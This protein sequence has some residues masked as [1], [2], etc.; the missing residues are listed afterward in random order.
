MESWTTTIDE[1][2][3][4]HE[5]AGTM[6]HEI[7][8]V[9]DLSMGLYVLPAGSVDPQSPHEQDEVYI[10]LSGRGRLTAGEQEFEA[11]AGS[12]LY[13]KKRVPHRFHDIDADLRVLVLFALAEAP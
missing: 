9:P 10:V 11:K 6:W 3:A 5:A 7:F 8:R 12:I 2:D 13:V 4:A 1:I